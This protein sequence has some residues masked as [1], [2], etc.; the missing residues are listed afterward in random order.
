MASSRKLLFKS[1]VQ[2]QNQSS[3]I[4]SLIPPIHKHLTLG[5]T[6]NTPDG[7]IHPSS[8]GKCPRYIWFWMHKL[9]YSN[10]QPHD[11]QLQLIFDN[12]KAVEMMMLKRYHYEMGILVDE[13]VLTPEN[14]FRIRGRCDA[15]LYSDGF[16]RIVDY[17][18]A[19]SYSFDNN[20]PI[21]KYHYQLAAYMYIL[22]V[23]IGTILY[24]NKNTSEMAE[25][26]ITWDHPDFKK[27]WELIA[28]YNHNFDNKIAPDVTPI[29]KS[30]THKTCPY[31]ETCMKYPEEAVMVNEP[32]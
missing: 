11:A 6:P 32:G 20:V 17:K 14:S 12:G 2:A 9:P 22:N 16:Y 24:Y 8:I 21:A 18:T 31:F 4:P 13:E 5:Q 3:G 30:C 15:I 27:S 25:S 10:W 23:K 7:F 26:H 29:R 19:N 1:V 28:E